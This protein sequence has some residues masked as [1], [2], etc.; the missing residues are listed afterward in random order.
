MSAGGSPRDPPAPT[1]SAWVPSFSSTVSPIPATPL[2]PYRAWRCGLSTSSRLGF[3]QL[4]I[5]ARQERA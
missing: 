5:F 3:I 4:A 2:I 1:S